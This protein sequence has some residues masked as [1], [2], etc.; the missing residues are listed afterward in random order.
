MIILIRKRHV[1]YVVLLCCFVAGLS[2]VLWHGNAAF[3]AAFA[4]GEEGASPVVVVD[5]G[6]GGEDGGAVAADGTVESGLNLAIARR[7]RDLL[8]FAGVPTT[9]TREGDAA[10]YDPGSAT[11]REKKVSDLHN[12][13]ALVNELPGAVL[14]SIHQNSLPS[15][16]STRGAQVFWNRQEGAEELASSI[17]ESLN[18]AVNAGHEKKAAQVPSSVYLMKE[19]TA[20]GVLVECGFLSNAAET[21]QL[22]DPA[23]QTKLAAAIAAGVLNSDKRRKRKAQPVCSVLF[24]WEGAMKPKTRFYCT[25]CGNETPKWAGKCPACGAWN[26]IV[27]QPQAARAAGKGAS[28]PAGGGS[29]RRARPVT[30]LEADAEIRFS[31]GM[32]ELDRVLGG[33]AVKGS[34]VL[35]GGAPGI[36][37]STLMLQ[38]CESLCRENKVLYVSGE[39]SEHQLKLR[40][41]R[42]DVQSERLFVIS[43]TSLGDLLESVAAEAPD[44]LIVDSIQTLY[45]DA[46]ESPAG[47]VSQVK[48]CTMALMQLAKGQGITVFVIGHVN[49]EGSIAGPKVLEHM[50]DCVLY[51]EGD[52]HT[53]YRIL[54][55]AKNRFGAT[56]EIGVFEMRDSG[57]VEVENPSEM[58]LSGR[59]EDAPGTCVTCVMEGARPVLAEIQALAV[60]SPAGNP[61]R[62]SNGFDYNRFAM[63]L[64][65]L[66]KRGGL[67]VSAC[68]AYLN[69]IGGL[70]LDEPAADLAAVIAL[71]SSY[72]DR[73]VPADLVA[74]GEVGLTGELRSV[75]Q[76]GQRVSEVRR[77]GF[78]QCLI[79]SRRTGELAAPAGLRLI[80]VRNIGEAIRAALR[81]SE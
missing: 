71:A 23:Y 74:I 17:Q 62:T 11:L 7:V 1:A 43:E 16:P 36:G 39:E 53:A 67:K 6:H 9:V 25:E 68:D 37:K 58:L 24:P 40:A 60:S 2:A 5:A 15:S 69:I 42:L 55:A 30:E 63:L 81:P 38:I 77:L 54:R 41:K 72:L 18:G 48:D 33:G 66:E 64:A 57:L 32:G 59:P 10:I 28:R 70:S 34:L 12:R 65:V 78:T 3:T 61:R 73:P 4:P 45:N 49:K 14:L 20:P 47:S 51:F 79:P 50:V 31:T 35:V 8:T 80:P 56:N 19:I 26:T 44:V 13:V 21:E 75:S 27:E 22:K 29:V 76:L 52:Q 46:L